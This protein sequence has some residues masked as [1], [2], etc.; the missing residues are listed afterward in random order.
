MYTEPEEAKKFAEETGVD[1]L[2][3]AIG[4]LHRMETQAAKIQ[5]DRLDKIQELTNVPIV[6]H[7]STGIT[8]DDLQKLAKYRVAKINIA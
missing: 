8:D 2:A 6:I 7:G 4:T 3:V 1:A 5:Y